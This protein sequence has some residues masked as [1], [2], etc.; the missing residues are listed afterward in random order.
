MSKIERLNARVAKLLS[1]AVHEV[2]DVVKE[3]VAEYQQKT[4]RTQRENESLKR[5]LLELQEK[6]LKD[7]FGAETLTAPLLEK[8]HVEKHIKQEKEILQDSEDNNI[9]TSDDTITAILCSESQKD[10]SS[11]TITRSVNFLPFSPQSRTV[12][13]QF[14]SQVSPIVKQPQTIVHDPFSDLNGTCDDMLQPIL[15]NDNHTLDISN[16]TIPGSLSTFPP[17]LS[18]DAIKKE[19]NECN[20]FTSLHMFLEAAESSYSI[21]SGHPNQELPQAGPGS[22]SGPCFSG[23]KNSLEE[24]CASSKTA[25]SVSD[26]R[27]NPN[28][29][30]YKGQDN[31]ITNWRPIGSLRKSHR[32]ISR[33]K[34][35]FCP[36]C[37]R[38]FNHA[39]DFKKHK[40]V[41]TGE[42]PYC[43]LVCGKCFS[44]A[45]Y[46][47]IHQRFHT[48]E[49]P[50]GCAQCGKWFS[51]SSNLKKHQRT[52]L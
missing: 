1:L 17:R 20:S 14:N 26:N 15:T 16:P 25:A 4:A 8:E 37:G 3:T 38:G 10:L 52:H 41:H 23:N 48:G 33:E 22:C 19:P 7:T 30:G 31:V 12:P 5:R 27:Y 36:L 13:R 49:R 21:P 11:Q 6:L 50:Y 42:K 9:I 2:L 18:S 43:C 32:H 51:H 35:Y 28:G 34:R 39:G 47:K 44:Q 46:L 40:R 24:S 45:G 29:E